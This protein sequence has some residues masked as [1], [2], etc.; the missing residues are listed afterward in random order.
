MSYSLQLDDDVCLLFART[1]L[2]ARSYYFQLFLIVNVLNRSCEFLFSQNS[3]HNQQPY[4]LLTVTFI[5]LK[6]SDL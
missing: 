1:G 2:K 3:F 5:T 4:F 6:T